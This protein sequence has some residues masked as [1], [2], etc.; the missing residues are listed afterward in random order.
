MRP[1]QVVGVDLSL[2]S[3]GVAWEPDSTRRIRTSP[4]GWASEDDRLEHIV[5]MVAGVVSEADA[6][7]RAGGTLVVVEGLTYGQANGSAFTRA[8]LH[9]L[10]RARV[11]ADGHRFVVVPPTRLK[12]FVTG[13][14]NASKELMVSTM[15]RRVGR[16]LASDDIA[17]ALGLLWLGQALAGKV[18][19]V[20]G[21]ALT[22][23]Q[24][25]VI[26]KLRDEVDW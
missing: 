25:L 6:P 19:T 13:N 9:Y 23:D 7:D 17:D 8:G 4:K 3:T 22:K 12:R 11:R 14:G 15:A 21:T 2:V 10:V 18:D 26:K 16:L 1:A 24:G 20:A 5:E